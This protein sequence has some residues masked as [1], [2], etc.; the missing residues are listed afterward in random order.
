[1]ANNNH[2]K[3]GCPPGKIMIGGM[4]YDEE[5]LVYAD[6]VDNGWYIKKV[7]NQFIKDSNFPKGIYADELAEK[8]RLYYNLTRKTFG[9]GD[10]S[11]DWHKK[12]ED[13]ITVED[14]RKNDDGTLEIWWE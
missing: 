3:H 7:T 10:D 13:Y 11:S 9:Y 12:G 8:G 14:M 5:H 2:K 4:C 1:M 6:G